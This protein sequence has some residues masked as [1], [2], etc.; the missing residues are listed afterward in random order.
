MSKKLLKKPGVR[1]DS[2][3]ELNLEILEKESAAY[4][5]PAVVIRGIN[6]ASLGKNVYFSIKTQLALNMSNDTGIIFSINRSTG[7]VY[8]AVENEVSSGKKTYSFRTI[9][10][11]C[12]LPYKLKPHVKDGVYKVNLKPT[13]SKGFDWYLLESV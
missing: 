3:K 1:R 12:H 2:S 7:D 8:F 11:L 13:Y 9:T 5:F 4:E 6:Y 10:G